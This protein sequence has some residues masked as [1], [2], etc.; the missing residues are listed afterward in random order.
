MVCETKKPMTHAEQHRMIQ[1]LLDYARRISGRD[2][3]D[4]DMFVRRDKD[5]EDLDTISQKRLKELYEKYAKR[6]ETK[7]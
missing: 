6:K 5:D 7:G 3:Y 4:F 2:K 1:E